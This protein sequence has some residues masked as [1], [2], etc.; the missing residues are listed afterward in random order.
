MKPNATYLLLC[1]ARRL[2]LA[3][4]ATVLLGGCMFTGVEGTKKITDKEVARSLRDLERQQP[5]TTLQPHIDSVAT[6]QRGKLFH[7]TDRNAI[8]IL[9]PENAADT[10]SLAGA[11]LAYDG[12]TTGSALDNRA[13]LTLRFRNTATGAAYTLRT[14]KTIDEFGA[15]YEI[16]LLIDLDMVANVAR[17]TVGR[18]FYIKTPLWRDPDT[19]QPLDGRQFIA[20]TVT[21]VKPGNKALPLRVEFTAADTR[22]RAFVYMSAPGHE[23]HARDFDSL[24]STADL[25]LSYPEISDARWTLIT[26]GRVEADMTKEECRLALG[27]PKSINRL[28]DQTGLREYWHYDGGNYLFFVDGLLKQFRQ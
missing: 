26:R 14:N 7:V 21:D 23:M 18:Q 20:V 27:A 12:Y 4:A 28:P 5:S 24:F 2:L 11:T 15:S 17:Q 19:D 6:W 1:S 13:T 22:Q 8:H 16:P 10:A 9:R 25:R 3:L